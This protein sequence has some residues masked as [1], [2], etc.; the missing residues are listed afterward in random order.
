MKLEVL[1]LA[2]YSIPIF[3]TIL[4]EAALPTRLLGENREKLHGI[5]YDTKSTCEK[6]KIDKWNYIKLK[7]FCA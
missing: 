3:L 2:I 6:A 4:E 7:N 1:E 5:G